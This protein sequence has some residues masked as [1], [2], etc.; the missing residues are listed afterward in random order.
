LLG[1]G[2]NEENLSEI[3]KVTGVK[4][5]HGS[6]RVY[7]ASQMEYNNS[8]VSMGGTGDEYRYMIASLERIKQLTVIAKD[9]LQ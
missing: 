6:A 8:C 2:I 3:L 9:F 7:V 4:E 5:F 1:G